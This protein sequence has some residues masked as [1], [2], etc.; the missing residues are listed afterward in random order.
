MMTQRCCCKTP[1]NYATLVCRRCTN[2]TN[3]VTQTGFFFSVKG[4]KRETIVYCGDRWAD[5]AGNGLGYITN[6]FRLHLRVRSLI[7]IH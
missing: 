6:G 4:S 2:K 7:S 5:F 1:L 3:G